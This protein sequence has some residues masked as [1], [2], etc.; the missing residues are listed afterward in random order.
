MAVVG[1][2]HLELL[3]FNEWS[4][5]CDHPTTNG[6]IPTVTTFTVQ[7]S[8]GSHTYKMA[9]FGMTYTHFIQ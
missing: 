9:G 6:V 3:H 4:L 2:L 5:L 1:V 7:T 8:H